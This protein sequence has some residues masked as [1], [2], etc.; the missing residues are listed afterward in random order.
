M[1]KAL[2]D[3]YIS[4][5]YA[6]ISEIFTKELNFAIKELKYI[7]IKDEN[8][9]KRLLKNNLF[10]F[11]ENLKLIINQSVEEF[12]NLFIENEEIDFLIE[13]EF[14][15][16]K[17]FL[18]KF[19]TIE[20]I[21]ELNYKSNSTVMSSP[22]IRKGFEVQK[23]SKYFMQGEE[24]A[25]KDLNVINEDGEKIREFLG[26]ENNENFEKDEEKNWNIKTRKN[27]NIP[28]DKIY[29][30]QNIPRGNFDN[31]TNFVNDKNEDLDFKNKN[32]ELELSRNDSFG[33]KTDDQNYKIEKF[34]DF[35][36]KNSVD[37]KK[38]TSF[39]KTE[40]SNSEKR[41]KNFLKEIEGKKKDEN[42]IINF[43]E[44]NNIF[45][46][47]KLFKKIEKKIPIEKKIKNDKF[48]KKRKKNSPKRKSEKKRNIS[49]MKNH[50]KILE[51]EKRR[52]DSL[53][54]V[55]TTNDLEKFI[56]SNS[57]KK[58][59]KKLNFNL[60]NRD[61]SPLRKYK[62]KF[63]KKEEL[64]CDFSNKKNYTKKIKPNEEFKK[65]KDNINKKKII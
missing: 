54:E 1:E 28:N 11:K 41:E 18:K 53:I 2:K 8:N 31:K 20:E 56:F 24:I 61:K 17:G 30:N 7:K 39:E 10:I 5:I 32:E 19:D 4:K 16:K 59:K 23:S 42:N 62:K 21:D 33:Q 43:I 65:M 55:L 48:F 36:K 57:K 40:N 9:I 50:E 63:S 29:E 46:T 44:N 38:N 58:T 12:F 25:E 26:N 60:K 27:D 37:T 15:K 49:A 52:K 14:F 51:N 3:N 6:T 64:N 22:R 35:E 34:C 13:N 45:K 47:E